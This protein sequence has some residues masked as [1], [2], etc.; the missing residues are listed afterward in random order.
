MCKWGSCQGIEE[1]KR[2]RQGEVQAFEGRTA[3]PGGSGRWGT[4]HRGSATATEQEIDGLV[5]EKQG[6]VGF[7]FIYLAHRVDGG[8]L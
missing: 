6:Y 1:A 7:I 4:R 2:L 5:F 8:Q 3:T